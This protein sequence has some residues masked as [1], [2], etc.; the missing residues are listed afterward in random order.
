MIAVPH[1][2]NASNGLMFNRRDLSG[3]PLTR[4]YAERRMTNEP[5]A[6]IIQGK[7]QSDTSPALSP[8]DEFANFEIWKYL[9]GTDI[10]RNLQTAVN[11]TGLWCGTGIQD[12]LGVN[13]FKY[14]IEAG[15]DYHSALS[16]TEASNYPG[17]HGL[18][19]NDPRRSLPRPLRLV[20]NRRQ[21]SAPVD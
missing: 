9:I 20:G 18:Q 5:L 16:S 2:G 21:V 1:N 8:T 11:P 6:E 3:K 4:D 17:S 14:G 12:T 19:D 7:G 13:P 15:T 10:R